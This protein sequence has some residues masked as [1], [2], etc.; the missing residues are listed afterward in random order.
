MSFILDALRK[1]ERERQ[2][3]KEP[4]VAELW[5]HGK[6]GSRT[7]WIPLV[8]LLVGL[9]FS[10]LLFLWIKGN[11]QPA[12]EI[13]V[14]EQ[15]RN[16]A[17]TEPVTTRPRPISSARQEN[18]AARSLSAEIPVTDTDTQTQQAAA[19][20]TPAK[21]A[22]ASTPAAAPKAYQGLP[23]LLELSLAGTVSLP[24]LHLDIHVYSEQPAE[25]FVFINMRKYREGD[26]LNE[27]P[28]VDA[29]TGE[30]VVLAH[31]GRRFIVTRE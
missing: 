15:D 2:R 22:S 31:Q 23:S 5:T 4:G 1:S 17:V 29:I 19:A 20:I 28:V 3:T 10:L 18:Q 25:R 9:N 26:T 6:R 8:M 30:G 13:T 12:E 21:P 7:F 11:P 14:V 16:I 27:G 24:P